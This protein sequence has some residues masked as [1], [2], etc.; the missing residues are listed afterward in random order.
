MLS[1]KELALFL[2]GIRSKMTFADQIVSFGKDIRFLESKRARLSYRPPCGLKT[3][4]IG[5]YLETSKEIETSIKE[6][7]KAEEWLKSCG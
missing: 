4:D 5:E 1:K 7:K 6:K 2:N 3:K